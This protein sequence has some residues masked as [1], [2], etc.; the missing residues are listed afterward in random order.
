[1]AVLTDDQK[2]KLNDAND[3]ETTRQLTAMYTRGY[4]EQAKVAGLSDDQITSMVAIDVASDKAGAQWDKENMDKL[5]ANGKA[6]QEAMKNG[7]T[8][9]V[10]EL[11]AQA[12]ELQIP[13]TEL[14]N[15][16]QTDTFAIMTDAQKATWLEYSVLQTFFPRSQAYNFTADQKS[17]IKQACH[18]LAQEKGATATSLYTKLELE[19]FSNIM[20]NDQK[21]TYLQKAVLQGVNGWYYSAKLT[22]DQTAK[23]KESYIKL[24]A[25]NGTPSPTTFKDF[26]SMNE[27][28]QD[29]CK[30]L[31][32][33]VD[34]ML[35]NE[36]KAAMD[37][38]LH[39][40]KKSGA[41]SAPVL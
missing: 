34:A 5:I 26:K 39:P 7:D 37:K 31:S 18:T 10:K 11:T 23:V 14:M 22:V 41:T 13:R 1:M 24:V 3:A 27:A 35:S 19:T 4:Q 9:K 15:K 2:T 8:E 33:Q 20:T 30:K 36:Q 21:M 38:W 32:P 16:R 6:F 25:D 29:I 40:Q 12:L 28:V 17:R